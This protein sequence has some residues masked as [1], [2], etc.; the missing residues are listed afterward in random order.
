MKICICGGGGLGHVCAGIFVSQGHSVNIFT[1]HPQNW[2]EKIL[3]KDKFGKEY[4]G[5]LNIISD[6][7]EKTI[8]DVDIVLHMCSRIFN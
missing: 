1:G 3:V 4:S 2:S 6:S 8:T 5:Q 7:P